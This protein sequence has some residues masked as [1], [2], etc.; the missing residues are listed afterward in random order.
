MGALDFLKSNLQTLRRDIQFPLRNFSLFDS[1][2]YSQEPTEKS[3]SR[4]RP[5]KLH[6]SSGLSVPQAVD[7]IRKMS[8][9]RPRM[10][11]SPRM[12][13]CIRSEERRVGKE[14]VSRETRRS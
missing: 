8:H 5:T 14:R 2:N 12:K 4:K 9:L 11:F 6:K 10:S 1:C 13:N 7:K 3:P